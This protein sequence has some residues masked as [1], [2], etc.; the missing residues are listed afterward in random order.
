[1]GVFPR[2]RVWCM[3]KARTG[4]HTHTVFLFACLQCKMGCSRGGYV[5]LPAPCL[6]LAFFRRVSTDDIIY[7]SAC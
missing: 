1:M 6:A 2:L 7:L 5:C 3:A 4:T